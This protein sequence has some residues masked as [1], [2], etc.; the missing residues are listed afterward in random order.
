[1]C[2]QI[3]LDKVTSIKILIDSPKKLNTYLHIIGEVKHSISM[4]SGKN[5][6]N[7]KSLMSIFSLDISKPVT[8]HNVPVHVAEELKLLV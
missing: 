8:I 2:N 7:G 3:T 6:I 5:C 4:T 1:M